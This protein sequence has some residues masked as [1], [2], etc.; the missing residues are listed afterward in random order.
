MYQFQKLGAPVGGKFETAED[1]TTDSP[2]EVLAASLALARRNPVVARVFPVVIAK[3]KSCFDNFDLLRNLVRAAGE[4]KTLGFFLELTFE[5]T[6]EKYFSFLADQLSEFRNGEPEDFFVHV[7]KNKYLQQLEDMNTP[8]VAEK[9]RF[10]MNMNT[11]S[12]ATIFRKFQKQ[13]CNS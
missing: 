9:W 6:G 13:P 4:T 10:R 5:L 12:F 7:K 1:T 2:E 11:D 3:N 8:P